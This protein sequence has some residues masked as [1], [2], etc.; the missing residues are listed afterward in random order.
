LDN[1]NRKRP[2]H[3]TVTSSQSGKGNVDAATRSI[4]NFSSRRNSHRTVTLDSIVN[5]ITN[6]ITKKRR[7]G[8][9]SAAGFEGGDVWLGDGGK[10]EPY[11]TPQGQVGITPS[12]WTATSLPQGTKIYPSIS[13]MKTLTGIDAT[14]YAKVPKFASGGTYKDTVNASNVNIQALDRVNNI[15]STT[16]A[17][18][19]APVPQGVDLSMVSQILQVISATLPA[20][21]KATEQTANRPNGLDINGLT[22][23]FNER[24]AF[25][26]QLAK[27]SR[28]M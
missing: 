11:V 27:S 13:A 8:A 4:D 22:K 16:S 28:G 6:F 18:M 10:N 5:N 26:E 7:G 20:I 12:D 1:Y 9:T 21:Q 19:S 14:Q 2:Q 25:N 24:I 23:E 15:H 17:Q 3:K